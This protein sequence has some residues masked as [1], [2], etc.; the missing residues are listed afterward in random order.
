MFQEE[1]LAAAE[2]ASAKIKLLKKNRIGYLALAVL[3]GIFI[4]FGVLLSF[5]IGGM[6]QDEPY[7]K[8]MMGIFFSVAL[9]L[10]VIA[11]AELFTGNNFVMAAGVIRKTVTKA[12]AVKLWIICWI[13][14]L[15]G[16]VI[17]AL[18]YHLSGLGN[19]AVGEF[20]AASALAKMSLAPMEAFVRAMLCNALVCL[21]VWCGFR[22]KTESG[23]LIMIF[24]CIVAFFTTGFE[25]SVAN[26]TLLSVSLL[27]PMGQ[28]V[29]MGGWLYNLAIVTAGNIVGG[30]CF[31]AL[32]YYLAAKE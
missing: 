17:L 7:V 4:G 13:G 29:S 32:P 19:G 9:S 8:I 28:A 15:I 18:L 26:M 10:V 24:W 11:G 12:E 2:A 27:N 25:H 20:M 31:V 21:A 6:L 16:S 30:V 14:N 5:T 3:A 23:K 22:A 1:Y